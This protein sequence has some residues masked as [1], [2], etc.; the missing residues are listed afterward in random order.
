MALIKCTECG[1]EIDDGTLCADCEK[2]ILASEIEVAKKI[3]N[4]PETLENT[5]VVKLLENKLRREE[6]KII[7]KKKRKTKIK[8]LLKGFVVSLVVL[9]VIALVG[10]AIYLGANYVSGKNLQKEGQYKEAL[11]KFNTYGLNYLTADAKKECAQQAV[12]SSNISKIILCFEY[13]PS[14]FTSVSFNEAAKESFYDYL[15]QNTKK[16]FNDEKSNLDYDIIGCY[17]KI[18]DKNFEG[19]KNSSSYIDFFN[20]WYTRYYLWRD[21]NV[22]VADILED[23]L[24][25]SLP[26]DGVYKLALELLS[27]DELIL[28]FLSNQDD[29]YETQMAYNN[30][31]SYFYSVCTWKD[32]K[33][34][35]AFDFYSKSNGRYSCA[36]KIEKDN[37]YED[38]PDSYFVLEDCIYYTGVSDTDKKAHCKIKI[39]NYNEI[40]VEN[41]YTGKITIFKRYLSHGGRI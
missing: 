33:S 29:Y 16:Y 2:N 37:P 39:L 40:E 18:L 6:E 10:I 23:Y 15:V 32:K 17:I 22:L 26:E 20:K 5:E 7:R 19:Y 3:V 30:D 12:D 28:P 11:V 27:C 36:A 8:K 1:K 14:L 38:R 24:Y 35:D 21:N 25:T 41:Y 4:N 31:S 9:I 34:E 13:E